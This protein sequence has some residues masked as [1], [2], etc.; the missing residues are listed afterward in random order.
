M[1]LERIIITGA[2][3]TGKKRLAQK[4]AKRRPDLDVISYGVL[5]LREKWIKR[6]ERETT[7]A[8][9]I[10]LTQDTRIL[11]GGPSLLGLALRRCHGVIWLDPPTLTRAFRRAIRH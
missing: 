2:N 4:L 10:L 11:E 3:G 7:S 8:L 9:N 6:P 1:T 5:R